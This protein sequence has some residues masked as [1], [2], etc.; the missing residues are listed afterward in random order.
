M[1]FESAIGWTMR[2]WNCL[3]GCSKKSK[4]CMNCYAILVAWRLMHNP[5]PKIAKR[6]EGV[7][8]RNSAGHLNWT[9]RI[10]FDD[11]ILMRPLQWREPSRIFVNSES[12]IFHRKVKRGWIDRMFA[13]MALCPQHTF[14]VLTKEAQTAYE[15]L[16]DPE[17]PLRIGDASYNDHGVLFTGDPAC[18]SD[19]FPYLEWPLPNVWMGVS[20]E[21]QETADKRIPYLLQAPA[22]VRWISAEPLLGPVDLTAI[23]FGQV[24]RT[25]KPEPYRL[26]C[27]EPHYLLFDE[28][29]IELGKIDWVVCGGE[30]GSAARPMHPDWARSLRDQCVAAGVPF[31][32]KQWGE[33]APA[34]GEIPQMF[35]RGDGSED[36]KVSIEDRRLVGMRRVGKK[37]AGR[38][39]DG[40]TWD[41]Y[42]VE[43][44][45]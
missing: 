41:E 25:S 35:V 19:E 32:F 24:W 28:G 27:L 2:T 38:M 39:L 22:A 4:G 10:N 13:V 5:N 23:P 36:L 45:A 42:P 26:S 8:E 33:H 11:E 1:S 43:V 34:N 7:V 29:D 40:R 15:Y 37:A 21:D 3:I 18:V 17:T 14:Q 16:S 6:Y 20:T 44:E 9:G 30:S 31:F 12:D